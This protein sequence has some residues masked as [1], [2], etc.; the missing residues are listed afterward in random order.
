M[1]KHGRFSPRYVLRVHPK[2]GSSEGS[3]HPEGSQRQ[4]EKSD[5][6]G[7]TI[8][9]FCQYGSFGANGTRYIQQH[10]N[11][12]L[13]RKPFPQK[14]IH[15]PKKKTPKP[16]LLESLFLMFFSTSPS[17]PSNHFPP[18]AS[19]LSPQTI[20]PPMW[21]K[22]PARQ[23]HPWDPH[24]HHLMGGSWG[25]PSIHCQKLMKFQNFPLILCD[26]IE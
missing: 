15:T 2:S 25:S 14:N 11:P 7:L 23:G 13:P 8:P 3:G 19:P 16:K 6:P 17:K 12:P 9:N 24:Y 22:S 18:P 26:K 20:A 1:W 5:N 21:K 4:G 10:L